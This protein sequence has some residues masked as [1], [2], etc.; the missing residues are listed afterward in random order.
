MDR[1]DRAPDTIRAFSP[2][3]THEPL[4]EG[5]RFPLDKYQMLAERMVTLG[6]QVDRAP[7][8]SRA[9]LR[10]V[11][12][13]NYVTKVETGTLS[14]RELRKLGFPMTPDLFERSCSS[15]GS[16]LSAF[17]D[18]LD[19]GVGVSLAGG[20]HHAY[21]DHGE[22]FCV[23]NDHAVVA[24]HAFAHQL[25]RKVL[26]VDVDVHQGNGTAAIFQHEPRVF[27]LSLHGARNYPFHKE[28]SDRDVGLPDGLDD[29]EY[30]DIFAT[31]LDNVLTG[32]RPDVLLF[33]AGV[34]VLK[35]D[36]FGRLELTANGVVKRDSL[37]YERCFSADI[38]LVYNMGGGYQK[39]IGVTVEAHAESLQ[40]L[41]Q[42][43]EAR[44][45]RTANTSS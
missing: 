19:T 23:F 40:T 24:Y 26:I 20:T 17:Y 9:E 7:T 27:T 2:S 3:H 30:V 4:P 21:P 37:V 42:K 29:D 28:P 14:R 36:R 45:Q 38:P 32:F 34:D 1:P 8:A 39:D 15:V 31:E 11:H 5:H 18:A 16:T 25:A 22:G 33:Q 12:T 10:R 44:T 35:G 41:Q 6:W 13:D 43:Y